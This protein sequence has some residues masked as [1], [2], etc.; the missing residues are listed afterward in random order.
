LKLIVDDLFP[1]KSTGKPLIDQI[2]E[3]GKQWWLLDHFIP[4]TPDSLKTGFTQK[5]LDWSNENEGLIWNYIKQ[6]ENP[7][8]IEPVVIQTYL[9][10]SPYTQGMPESSPG[11]LGQWVGL[12][13]VKKFV[14]N[15]PKL[16]PGEVMRTDPKKILEEA[17]Y[18]PK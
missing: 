14:R 10:E 12:Q 3:K 8:S 7:Y 2:I 1:E 17:K 9:G 15:N 13:I 18:K 5:Q 11:N 16:H 6:N 4:D